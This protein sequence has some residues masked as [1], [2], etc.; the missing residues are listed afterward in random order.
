MPLGGEVTVRAMNETI[1]SVKNCQLKAGDYIKIVIEDHGRGIP[2][3]KLA[4]I[5]D[6][7]F[8]TKPEGSGL[9]LASVYSIV[10]RHGGVVEVSSIT[11]VGS[12]FTIRLPATS[13]MRLDGEVIGAGAELIGNGRILI[14]DDEEIIRDVVTEI[15]EFVGFDVETCIDGNQA[16]E[17]FRSARE[18]NVPY[19][20][21][22]LDLTIPG[23]MGG[24]EAAERILE[25]DPS[26][27]LIVS[28]GYSNDP[29]VANCRQYGFSG[30]VPKPFT[31]DSLAR[32]LERMLNRRG[33]NFSNAG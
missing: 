5:F 2:P 25:I 16:V 9:G 4:R 1:G 15:L 3:E 17:H 30:A 11:G 33:G 22:I 29:V 28:S 27:V 8:T 23:G 26:A 24:R 14:M 18:R 7:Y 12:S 13:C 31:A 20:A 6:P 10:R 19:D 21:I 32:E